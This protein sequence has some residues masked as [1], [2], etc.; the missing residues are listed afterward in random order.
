MTAPTPAQA[1][2]AREIA[3]A[4][5]AALFPGRGIRHKDR[6]R[7]MLPII[8][9]ALAEEHDRAL[10]FAIEKAVPGGNICD[11]QEIADRIRALKS[12]G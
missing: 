3:D 12:D 10:D 8:A 6:A 9:Q 2:R 11:P 4:C 7:K 5:S 1:E